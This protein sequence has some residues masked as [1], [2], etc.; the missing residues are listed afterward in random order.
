MGK[1]GLSSQQ[2]KKSCLLTFR[3]FVIVTGEGGG[4]EKGEAPCTG[5]V[6]PKANTEKEG[7]TRTGFFPDEKDAKLLASVSLFSVA[8]R[9]VS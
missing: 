9:T 8:R 5:T 7:K 4:E 6:V 2:E 1:V 3:T